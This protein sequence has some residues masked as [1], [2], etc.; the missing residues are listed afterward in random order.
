MTYGIE[1]SRKP[2]K[3]ETVT[4]KGDEIEEIDNEP[5]ELLDLP[6]EIIVIILNKM[7]YDELRSLEFT[8]SYFRVMIVEHRVYSKIYQ[9]LPYYN[10]QTLNCLH[11]LETNRAITNLQLSRL[12]KKKLHQYHYQDCCD[13]LIVIIKILHLGIFKRK[14]NEIL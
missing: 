10:K 12:C 8:C 9:S 3:G 6:A 11:W 7:E 2:S 1:W 13:L 5:I 4:K 14:L